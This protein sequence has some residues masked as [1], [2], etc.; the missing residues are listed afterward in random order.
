MLLQATWLQTLLLNG[1]SPETNA[2][3]IPGYVL[4]KVTNGVTI[5]EPQGPV[6]GIGPSVYGMGQARYTYQGHE[7]CG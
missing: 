4:D 1:R 7:V 3:V 5:L 6:P 2:I